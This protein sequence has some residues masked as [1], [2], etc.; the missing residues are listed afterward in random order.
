M[1]NLSKAAKAILQDSFGRQARST[2]RG[3]P[4][5]K[6]LDHHSE[7]GEAE[8]EPSETRLRD[9]SFPLRAEAD[10]KF[11]LPSDLTPKE[12]ER[13]GQFLKTLVIPE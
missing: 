5:E 2:W 6:M 7:G 1:A 13:L 10:A 9:Y 11:T 3:L 4:R 8:E 12:A